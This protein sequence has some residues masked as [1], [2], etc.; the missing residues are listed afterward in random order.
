MWVITFSINE[1]NQCGDYF[2]RVFDHKPT[3][4]ELDNLGYDGEHLLKGGGRK[5]FEGQ[6]F[7]LTEMKSG[8][9]YEHS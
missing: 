9:Q 2:D 6:W 7:H 8:E 3:K 4:E 1:Y 5:T